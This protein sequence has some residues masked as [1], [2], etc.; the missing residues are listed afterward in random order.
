MGGP[1]L[2]PA[3]LFDGL[4][5][6]LFCTKARDH[7]Y[8]AANQAFADRAGVAGPADVVG[9]RAADLFDP[10]LAVSY[11]AQDDAVFAGGGP[12]HGLLELIVRPEGPPGWFV[13]NKELLRSGEIAAVSVDLRTAGGERMASVGAAIETART[14]CAEPLH[15]ADLAA[16][17]NLSVPALERSLRR[18]L[19]ISARQLVV[20][21]RVDEAARRL[22]ETD[23]PLGDIAATL[24]WYDQAAFTHQFKRHTG[25]T[26]AAYRR[27]TAR[28]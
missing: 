25:M 21:S 7:R 11:E 15:A 9:R 4:P 23:E 2:L 18:V 10:E 19:G 20:R 5:H 28:P 3:G 24:G 26:P 14:R 12:L 22:S 8:T 6:V 27:V 16:A 13:T 1:P 17:A